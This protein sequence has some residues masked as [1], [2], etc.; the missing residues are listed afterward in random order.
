MSRSSDHRPCCPWLQSIIILF[1]G[2]VAP[3]LEVRLGLGGQSYRE[4][5]RSIHL[6]EVFA[7]KGGRCTTPH[8]LLAMEGRLCS[9]SWQ[10]LGTGR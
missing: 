2:I 7:G 4:F 3:L 6:P 8:S 10:Q 9:R 1:G 5:I